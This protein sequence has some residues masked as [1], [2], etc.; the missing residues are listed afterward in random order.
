MP[1]TLSDTIKEYNRK[2]V[3]FLSVFEMNDV[4]E[5]S[6]PK[7][8]DRYA[9]YL[10]KS[11]AD[12]EA[13]KLGEGE[14]LARHKKIL[15]ELAARK[16]LYV[17]KIYQEIVS[18]AESIN[19]RPVIKQLIEDC[20]AG[21]YRGIIIVE[22]TRLSRGSQ[23]DAQIIMDCLKY[24]N[25]NN[26]LLVVTPTK[27][28]DVAHNHDDEEYMEFELFMSRREY[29]MIKRRMDR[30]REQAVVEGNYM[31]SYR[32][33]GYDILKSK[34]AR[35]LIPNPEEAPIVKKIF[36]WTVQ[37]N[38]TPWEIAKKLTALGIP[39]YSGDKEW[40]RET[41]KTILTNPTYTGKVRWND[42]MRVKTM[43]NGEL[44]ASRP[45][46]NHSDRYMEYEGKHKAHALIDEETFKAA[47][48]RF[49]SDKTK[50]NLKL[51]NILA[52]L[53]VCK[54]CG[55]VMQYQE[56]AKK[57]TVKPRF[58]HKQSQVCK[59]K[60]VVASDV[61]NALVHALKLYIEDFE[62]KVDNLPD[63]DENS[64]LGQIE[65]LQKEI[66][67]IEKKL[68]KLFDA[69][70]DDEITDNEFVQRKAVHNERI[71][72]IKKQMDDLEDAIPEKEEYEEKI[73]MLSDA[74]D[75][76]LDDGLDAE[77]KNVY[78]KQIVDRIEFSRET[79]DE[80]VLDV[81]LK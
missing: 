49:Y 66:R 15:T 22:V 79:D 69:W 72:A 61:L 70:E 60:S 38:L 25:R 48:S 30:G 23:G 2:E 16:G 18:G 50:G 5:S 35:T 63:V 12:L 52:G 67:R 51:K 42:R 3:D 39:T 19:D 31:G 81:Y 43:V 77:V 9:I 55:K 33:Y 26:G 75:S 56:Y 68:A 41:V 10:R 4:V 8:L 37:H 6:F 7:A 29:K 36:E 27:T 80:F 45:R 78:L 71:E 20:Y 76:L 21:K 47:S 59:V 28:Y 53:L 1:S 64:I 58:L 11:R 54:N 32:P 62:E 57:P 14:T 65:A 44:V 34:T 46:S 73:F 13:E 40:S 24:S 17:E 74:L